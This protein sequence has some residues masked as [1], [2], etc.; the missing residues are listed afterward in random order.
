MADLDIAPKQ[1]LVEITIAEVSLTDETRFGIEWFLDGA[2]GGGTATASTRGGLAREPGGLGATFTRT[3][4]RGTVQAALNAISTNRNLNILSTPRLV[5]R[6]GS[7]AQILVGS[8][9]PIITSQRAADNQTNGDSDILQTVQ[10]RQTGVILNMKPVVYGSDRVDIELFQEVST[11]QPNT[12]SAI[13]SPLILNR[14]VTTQLSLREGMT[15][16]I[17]GMI[18]DSYSRQ[19][20]GIP[21]LKDIPLIGQAFRV[22][23]V[24]GE[25]V[26]LLILV[27]PY[28]IRNDERMG[29]ASADYSSS[30]NRLLQ[31]RGPQVYTMLPWRSPFGDKPIV[32]GGTHI[33]D[34]DRKN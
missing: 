24:T 32:H 31:T 25:K 30:I 17:G 4:S 11:Q 6:S 9:V 26:E 1:V 18:Q 10:Y 20:K 2:L 28:I 5:A 3:F 14:S 21:I 23:G 34:P 33:G 27:T 7:T 19:Q 15:A 12:T 8:D 29:L 22:D 13:A 16:V